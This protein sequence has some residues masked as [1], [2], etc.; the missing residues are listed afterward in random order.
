MILLLF[1]NSKKDFKHYFLFFSYIEY[2]KT[3]VKLMPKPYSTSCIDYKKFGYNYNYRA[4]CIFK[5]KSEYY[6]KKYKSWFR[7]LFTDDKESNLTMTGGEDDRDLDMNI[8]KIFDE[9]YGSN[10][11]CF[12][13]YF[14]RKE[15]K[16]KVRGNKEFKI[17]INRPFFKSSSIT[18]SAKIQIEDNFFDNL[19]IAMSCYVTQYIQ[20]YCL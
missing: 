11:D 2:E 5:C 17:I 12:S 19:I 18:Y 4:E 13:E 3:K 9:F 8:Q 15:I 14:E 20:S 6:Y 1:T 10:R 16:V 7:R